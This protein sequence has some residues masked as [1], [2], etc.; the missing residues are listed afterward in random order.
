MLMEWVC[1]K[2]LHDESRKRRQVSNAYPYM[3]HASLATM[4]CEARMNVEGAGQ[5]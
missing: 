4:G 2:K 5:P 3:R 1:D